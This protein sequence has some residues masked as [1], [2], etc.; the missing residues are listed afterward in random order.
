MGESGV[1]SWCKAGVKAVIKGLVV[2]PIQVHNE[3]TFTIT[4]DEH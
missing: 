3:G 1:Y 4:V 2:G